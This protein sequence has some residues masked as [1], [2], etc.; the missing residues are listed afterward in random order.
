MSLKCLFDKLEN[1]INTNLPKIENLKH[2]SNLE[3]EVPSELKELIFGDSES[4]LL[5]FMCY[6]KNLDKYLSYHKETAL[7]FKELDEIKTE[8][9]KN[10]EK[11]IQASTSLD[12]LLH[13]VKTSMK[14]IKYFFCKQNHY[15]YFFIQSH[16]LDIPPEI[17]IEYALK[18]N[19]SLGIQTFPFPEVRSFPSP[20]EI[21]PSHINFYNSKRTD[22]C[23]KTLFFLFKLNIHRFNEVQR[24]SF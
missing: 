20:E 15:F 10:Q 1:F 8:S 19:D 23:T 16:N 3:G 11:L 18:I 6:A 4:L 2:S 12:N 22:D 21:F 14:E 24:S 9:H 17:I 7:L 5:N 13:E